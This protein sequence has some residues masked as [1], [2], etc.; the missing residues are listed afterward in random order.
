LDVDDRSTQEP[1]GPPAMSLGRTVFEQTQRDK[2]DIRKVYW[3]L[4]K[5]EPNLELAVLGDCAQ[6]LSILPG[7]TTVPSG[8]RPI[9]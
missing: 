9:E 7:A 4:S 5:P 8:L 3:R 6:T 1:A 2:D